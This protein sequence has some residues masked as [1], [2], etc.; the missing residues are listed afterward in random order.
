MNSTYEILTDSSC[1]MSFQMAQ[2]LGITVVAM[3]VNVDGTEQWNRLEGDPHAEIDVKQFYDSLRGG[4]K[5]STTAVNPE[6][7]AN[8]AREILERGKDVLIL[9][10]SSGLSGTC[11]SAILAAGELR[12]EYPQRTILVE[13]SLCASLGQGLL[14]YYAAKKQQEGATIQE[15]AQWVEE[16]RLH[17]CHWFTVNDLMFLKRGGRISAT[18]AVAGTLLNIKPVL[19]MDNDGKL[20]NVSKARG[21]KAAIDALVD[22]L[23]KT[24]YEP[25]KQVFFISHGDCPEDAQYLEKMLREKYHPVDVVVGHVGPVIGSHSGPGTLALFF[26]GSER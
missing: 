19:H 12:E 21:R 5:T 10:F 22:R 18:T 23:G 6:T 20:A 8:A 9:P 15:T 2:E 3:N 17:L 7:W 25:S 4:A 11:G 1:D 16:N 26:L 24:A 14:V 13:D